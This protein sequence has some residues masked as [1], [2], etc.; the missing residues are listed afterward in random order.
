MIARLLGRSCVAASYLAGLLLF[1]QAA[2]VQAQG[3][4]QAAAAARLQRGR[5]LFSRI[6]I[7]ASAPGQGD[8]L[9]PMFNDVS[10]VACHSLGGVGGAGPRDKNIR[11]LTVVP[12]AGPHT[13]T[14]QADFGRRVARVLPAFWTGTSLRSTVVLH[15]SSTD[16]DYAT[17]RERLLFGIPPLEGDR[18]ARAIKAVSS[19]KRLQSPVKSV[20][21][22]GIAFR[23]SER[24]TTPLF[25]LGLI[26]KIPSSALE[27]I[28]TEQPKENPGVSGRVAP[29]GGR[30][31]WRG[32][33]ATLEDF[34]LTACSVELGL[35]VPEHHQAA[36][37]MLG[38]AANAPLDM[39]ADECEALV[40]FVASLRRPV[41][42]EPTGARQLVAVRNGEQ[43]FASV[44]CAACHVPDL[45]E[46]E[47]LYSDLLLHDMGAG[48]NDP[49]P[50]GPHTMQIQ[51][52]VGTQTVKSSGY[53][54]GVTNVFAV[55]STSEFTVPTNTGQEWKTPPLWGVASSAPYLHDGR[56]ATLDEAI[57][58][59]GGEA[60]DSVRRY[61]QLPSD[62]RARLIG[63]LQTLVAPH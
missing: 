41:Q 36:N 3:V 58:L 27:A 15:H 20:K 4:V 59:H 18:K 17:L 49:V 13:A 2:N 63:F 43:L 60:A 21:V 40:V 6:W 7:P 12:P 52:Q 56:A 14:E 30:F 28:A 11:L 10:C 45:G 23:S 26:D 8:G 19:R 9:G 61:S 55:F 37:P 51:T 39:T 62:G 29:G 33:I 48:L 53:A 25:G 32:Q 50:A 35:E 1:C 57:L 34:V 24:N 54:G 16:H 22:D 42:Q 46:V 31:G 5:E 38:P 47:G 44:G